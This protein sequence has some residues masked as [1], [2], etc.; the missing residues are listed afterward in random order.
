MPG[1]E[2]KIIEAEARRL[3][4]LAAEDDGLRSE[5]RAL[6][7]MI[8]AATEQHLPGTDRVE[9]PHADANAPNPDGAADSSP[10]RKSDG[11]PSCRSKVADRRTKTDSMRTPTPPR[12]PTSGVR[13]T[14]MNPETMTRTSV[15]ASNVRG[16][17]GSE[18]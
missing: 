6:A 7:E 15:A 12:L 10:G 16:P 18:G 11:G 3:I 14:G 5:L 8:L 9:S 1:W 2:M 4:A 17:S 13:P